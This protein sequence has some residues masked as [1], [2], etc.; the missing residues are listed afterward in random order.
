ME[1]FTEIL[2]GSAATAHLPA[3]ASDPQIA[4]AIAIFGLGATILGV[5]LTLG[6]NR[7]NERN[8]AKLQL[9]IIDG[10]ADVLAA[11]GR[12]GVTPGAT[13]SP[14]PISTP[15]KSTAEAPPYRAGG[16]DQAEQ[17]AAASLLA[18]QNDFGEFAGTADVTGDGLPD[19]LVE[20]VM[21]GETRIKV[22]SWNELDLELLAELR[23]QTG[24]HFL[25]DKRTPSTL[26]T[27]DHDGAALIEKCFAW[28]GRDFAVTSSPA[29]GPSDE[30]LT[31]P[32]WARRRSG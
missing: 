31:R 32:S 12:L 14:S 19:L 25:A 8:L 3:W 28:E 27:L 1:S 21:H 22:F 20:T 18:V 16:T 6:A 13:S 24:A 9:R 7:K 15:P 5:V 23:N 10:V 29:V 4:F 2:D 30:F 11:S 26:R 17:K